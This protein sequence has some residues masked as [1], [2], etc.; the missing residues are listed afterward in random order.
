MYS[1]IEAAALQSLRNLDRLAD[2][3]I[4]FSNNDKQR[5]SGGE[6]TLTLGNKAFQLTNTSQKLVVLLGYYAAFAVAVPACLGDVSQR[7]VE[8]LRTFNSKACQL[9]L[10]AG[11]MHVSSLCLSVLRYKCY[12][13]ES[14]VI[15]HFNR[16]RGLEA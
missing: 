5:D 13:L 8:L 4:Q 6:S 9:I 15:M 2:S 14:I 3:R 11:A 16:C 10:G 1:P 12:D 7:L